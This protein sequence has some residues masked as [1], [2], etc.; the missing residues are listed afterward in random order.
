MAKEKSKFFDSIGNDRIYQADEF[1]EY[2]RLFMTSGIKN[3]GT[4]LQVTATGAGMSVNVDYGAALIQGYGYWL[5]NDGGGV[6]QLSIGAA[7]SMARIDRIILKL[8][9]ATAA[10]KI[11]LTV[12]SGTPSASPTPPTLVRNSSVYELSLAQVQVNP[13][14]IK[15]EPANITDERY[16][17]TVC[18]LINSLITLDASTFE[19]EATKTLERLANQGYLPLTG[20]AMRGDV[21]QASG[22]GTIYQHTN[23]ATKGAVRASST[24]LTLTNNHTNKQININD[25]GRLY[26]A[27]KTIVNADGSING[28]D[29]YVKKSGDVMNGTLSMSGN[30]VRNIANP[31]ADSSA[32]SKGYADTRYINS[33]GD[34]MGGNL[35]MGSHRVSGLPLPQSLDEAATKGYVDSADSAINT[36]LSKLERNIPLAFERGYLWEEYFTPNQYKTFNVTLSNFHTAYGIFAIVENGV[37][38]N[39]RITTIIDNPTSAQIFIRYTGTDAVSVKIP[40]LA[41]GLGK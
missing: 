5:E 17:P 16:D 14:A 22:K 41:Y 15:V 24:G 19:A 36:R 31:S 10:R 2:F 38:D 8:D 33:S 4:N 39:W 12:R 21:T 35:N 29:D 26:Y 3:G 25:D 37:P 28:L 30:E 18:G 32:I 13:N 34:T 6:K 11:S 7:S 23:G 40:W 20:G 9:R 27:D 1:A